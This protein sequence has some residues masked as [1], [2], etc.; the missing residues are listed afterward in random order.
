MKTIVKNSILDQISVYVGTYHKYTN[1]SIFGEWLTLGDFEDIEEFYNA[2]KKLHADET[3]PEFM[4]QDYSAPMELIKY[5]HEYNLNENLFLLKD[6][7]PE[8]AEMI[9]SYAEYMGELS[10]EI[11]NEAQERFFG[12]FETY[13][14]LGEYFADEIGVLEIPQN[15]RYYFDFEKYGRDLS[16]DL[17]ECGNFYFQS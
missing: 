13:E 17:I 12:K 4:F 6:I 9:L 3:T 10:E 16:F 14:E 5:I 8:T 15:L 1:G 7:D 2:C 11:V